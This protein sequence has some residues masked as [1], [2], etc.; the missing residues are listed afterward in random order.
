MK[1]YK[2]KPIIVLCLSFLLFFMQFNA[3]AQVIKITIADI[4]ANP[5][6]YDWQ[7]VQVEG[8]VLSLNS[9]TCKKGDYTTLELD[10][11]SGK[12]LTIFSYGHFPIKQG[13]HVRVTGIY[14]KVI[15]VPPQYTFYNEIDASG[16]SI[17]KIK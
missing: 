7:I 3:T 4:Y 15:H 14:K 2:I 13:D 10:D 8:K 11:Q 9:K 1:A 6:K 17:E 16:G 12:S 5:N